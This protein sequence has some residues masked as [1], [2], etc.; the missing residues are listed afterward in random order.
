MMRKMYPYDFDKDLSLNYWKCPAC[1]KVIITNRKGNVDQAKKMEDHLIKF[2][3]TSMFGFFLE[4]KQ[5]FVPLEK[6]QK[7]GRKSNGNKKR[8]TT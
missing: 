2:H 5:I 8:I 6:D 3:E 7:E 4:N 1:Q